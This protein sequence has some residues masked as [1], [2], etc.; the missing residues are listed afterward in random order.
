MADIG[1]GG[2]NQTVIAIEQ[3]R[4]RLTDVLRRLA[5]PSIGAPAD[6]AAPGG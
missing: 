3:A 1:Q 2:L 4:G 6:G 5:D